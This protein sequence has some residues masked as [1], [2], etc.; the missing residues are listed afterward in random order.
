MDKETLSNYGWIVICT[1]VLAVMIALATPFGEYIKAGVWSTTNG[2]NDTLN[3]NMEIA[4]LNNDNDDGFNVDGDSGASD[5]NNETPE[6]DPISL[7]HKG[8]IPEGGTYTVIATG[9]ILT[10]GQSFPVPALGDEY[11]YGDYIYK[12]GY[13]MRGKNWFL[14]G[15]DTSTFKFW[16]CATYNKE[17]T[18]YGSPL[19]SIAGYNNRFM[20]YAYKDCTKIETLEEGYKLP[21]YCQSVAWMFVNCS[22]LKSIPENLVIPENVTLANNMFDGCTSL[23]TIGK[24]FVITY[25]DCLDS[26]FEDCTSLKYLGDDFTLNENNYSLIKMFKNCTSLE[27]LPNNFKM[28]TEVFKIESMFEGCSSL[29]TLPASFKLPKVDNTYESFEFLFKDCSSLNL[30]TAFFNSSFNEIDTFIDTSY[31]FQNCTSLTNIPIT[32]FDND[33]G[34]NE[35]TYSG[36]TN[37]TGTITINDTASYD[38][39]LDGTTKPI[40]VKCNEDTKNTILETCDNSNL[41]FEIVS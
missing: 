17:Q 22:T 1:L 29:K 3:K 27:Y 6:K 7:D 12:Y 39:F 23:E 8:T 37:L 28:P 20:F 41:T 25:A 2:L 4:G 18:I 5:N 36:C 11:I 33:D 10:G 26:M 38:N 15:G 35:G 31:M 21:E 32:Y 16:G 9:E 24:G 13:Y 30:P 40:L 14:M 19:N 34:A